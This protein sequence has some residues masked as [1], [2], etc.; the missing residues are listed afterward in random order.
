MLIVHRDFL[1]EQSRTAMIKAGIN[2]DDIGIIK[3]GY[4]EDRDRPIQIASLQT[5]QRRK[6]STPE[7]LGLIILDECHSTAF[8]KH[9]QTI[10][11]ETL[12]SIPDR[13]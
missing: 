6:N 13:H 11:Q 12:V 3:A 4:K 9:Y 5:L 1:V 8:H 7:D 2:P 10:K